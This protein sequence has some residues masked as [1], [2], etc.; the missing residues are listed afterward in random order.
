MSVQEGS[1]QHILQ[2]LLKD[3]FVYLNDSPS[4]QQAK[5]VVLDK[6]GVKAQEILQNLAM[7]R[8][9]ESLGKHQLDV[10][11]NHQPEP[12]IFYDGPN[13]NVGE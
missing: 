9:Q 2:H 7:T 8:V 5:D 1:N 3:D 6:A 13:R 4:P 12:P 11:F 10:F